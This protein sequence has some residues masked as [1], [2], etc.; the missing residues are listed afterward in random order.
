MEQTARSSSITDLY[1][2]GAFLL[3]PSMGESG[4]K[5]VYIVQISSL[6]LIIVL[7][8]MID[9]YMYKF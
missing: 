7:I 9:I 6:D 3:T 5:C 2:H 8:K 1:N 4:I